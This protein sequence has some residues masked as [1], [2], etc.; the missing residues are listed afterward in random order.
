[1]SSGSHTKEVYFSHLTRGLADGHRPRRLQLLQD[2]IKTPGCGYQ[3]ACG[4][5]WHGCKMMAIPPG[6][7]LTFQTGQRKRD[8]REGSGHLY[9]ESKTFLEIFSR[10]SLISHW[11]PLCHMAT[12][13]SKGAWGFFFFK[14]GT[15]SPQTK[16][17]SKEE[18]KKMHIRWLAVSAT[19]ILKNQNNHYGISTLTTIWLRLN[20]IWEK[21]VTELCTK[22]VPGLSNNRVFSIFLK[23]Y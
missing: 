16:Y 9:Q 7:K 12:P 18:E 20:C 22:Q 19:N 4:F 17:I 15:L 6:L 21:I 1:M 5:Q 10:L 8:K 2:V 11:P 3:P 14:L 13:L 23:Y